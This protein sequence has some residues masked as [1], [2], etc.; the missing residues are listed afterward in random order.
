MSLA[1]PTFSDVSVHA[2]RS[3][4]PL[5]RMKRRSESL[6]ASVWRYVARASVWRCVARALQWDVA[7]ITGSVEVCALQ[8]IAARYI[9]L[10]CIA[11]QCVAVR[12]SVLQFAALGCSTHHGQLLNCYRRAF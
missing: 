12:C 3:E 6:S 10:R 1:C 9:A 8:H 4:E 7:L 11:L 5:T 2:Q